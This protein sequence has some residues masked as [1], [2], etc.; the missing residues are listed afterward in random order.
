MYVGIFTD[1]VYRFGTA[2]AVPELRNLRFFIVLC[3]AYFTGDIHLP[4]IILSFT[5]YF[6]II[7]I[8]RSKLNFQELFDWRYTLKMAVLALERRL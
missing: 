6:Y 3:I 2:Y 5:N 8:I 4:A 1:R 7:F